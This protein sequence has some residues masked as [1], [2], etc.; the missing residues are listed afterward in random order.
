MVELSKF[1]G[2]VSAGI[3][4]LHYNVRLSLAT[5]LKRGTREGYNL[6]PSHFTTGTQSGSRLSP[7]LKDSILE[8]SEKQP[9]RYWVKIR[10][11]EFSDSEAELARHAGSTSNEAFSLCHGQLFSTTLSVFASSFTINFRPKTFLLIKAVVLGRIL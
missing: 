3:L 8:Y 9:L 4:I 10:L 7:S 2:F 5:V 11:V 1:T 6:P